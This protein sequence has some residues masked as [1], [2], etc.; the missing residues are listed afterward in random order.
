MVKRVLVV[1]YNSQWPTMYEEEKS[2]IL[3]AIGDELVAVEH[4]GST[5]VPGLPAKPVIDI[6]A[7]VRRLED[8]E[9][10]I[11]PLASL[12]FEYVPEYEE[13]IPERRYFRKGPPEARTHHLH[14][15]AVGSEFWD[16]TLLFRDLLLSRDDLAREY[17]NLKVQLA[18]DHREDRDKYTEA[19]GPFIESTLAM[20]RADSG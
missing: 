1:E 2:R 16:E 19:K 8:A 3:E 7:G 9:R 11:G 18:R 6:M 13:F 20:A 17:S 5:S 15:V 12:G 10:C 14:M 4:V